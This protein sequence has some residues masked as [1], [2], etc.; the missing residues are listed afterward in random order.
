MAARPD[1]H[2]PAIPGEGLTIAAGGGRPDLGM[3]ALA[4]Q[5]RRRVAMD[6]AYAQVLAALPEDHERRGP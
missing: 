4:Q 5:S 3:A 6:D 2:R 1:H